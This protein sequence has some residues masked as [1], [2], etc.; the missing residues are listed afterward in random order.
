MRPRQLV[1]GVL[2]GIV[3]TA[4]PA[5]SQQGPKPDSTTVASYRQVLLTLRD[6]VNLVSA[7]SAEFRRD[8]RTVGGETVLSRSQ[9]LVAAC[10]GAQRALHDTRPTLAGL[11]TNA[12]TRPLRD[13]LFVAM[14][15]LSRSLDVEC[16][17]GL[18]PEGPGAR[19]DT[20]RAWGPH[21]TAT[22]EQVTTAYH[23]AA[24]RLA[25]ALGIDLSHR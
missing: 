5:A 23:G 11:P 2:V 1:G 14:R 17:R 21:R 7:R 20:L 13:S 8:L 25:R 3:A 24:A 4:T 10:Q 16:L 18:A 22:L 12:D 19:A 9:R 6:S 15:N